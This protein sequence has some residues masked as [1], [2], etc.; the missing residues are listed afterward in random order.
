MVWGLEDPEEDFSFCCGRW[1]QAGD[2]TAAVA[3]A[4][5]LNTREAEAERPQV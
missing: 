2:I 4:C 3:C 1:E 5:G